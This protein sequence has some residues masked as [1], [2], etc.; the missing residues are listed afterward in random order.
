VTSV[1]AFYGE[2]ATAG[3]PAT[4][5]DLS[6]LT[7]SVRDNSTFALPLEANQQGARRSLIPTTG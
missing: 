6:N 2:H 5:A 1:K 3:V 4:S 7:N